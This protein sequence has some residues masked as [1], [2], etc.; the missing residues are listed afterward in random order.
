MSWHWH[1][2]IFFPG[3]AFFTAL[4]V[5]IRVITNSDFV[6]DFGL[7]A[8]CKTALAARP[9]TFVIGTVSAAA[10][11]AFACTVVFGLL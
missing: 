11:Y 2:S 7:W 9:T 6:R 10:I 1:W 3:A 5:A 4:I 8:D